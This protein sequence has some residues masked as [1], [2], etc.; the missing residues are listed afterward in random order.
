MLLHCRYHR[1]HGLCVWTCTIGVI[2]ASIAVITLSI[3]V[4]TEYIVPT[5]T[6]SMAVMTWCST[7]VVSTTAYKDCLG[8]LMPCIQCDV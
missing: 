5:H 1:V 7:A 6:Y 3:A 8:G 4:I 2:T